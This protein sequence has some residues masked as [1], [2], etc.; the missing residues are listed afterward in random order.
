MAVGSVK[1]QTESCG[2]VFEIEQA[3][4]TA[5]AAAAAAAAASAVVIMSSPLQ[6]LQLLYERQL[7]PR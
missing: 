3:A 4:A 5:A 7:R 1:S 6:L 2:Q